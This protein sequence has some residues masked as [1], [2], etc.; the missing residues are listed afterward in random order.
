MDAK[1]TETQLANLDT[2][3]SVNHDDPSTVAAKWLKSQGLT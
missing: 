2:E 3:V 1:L